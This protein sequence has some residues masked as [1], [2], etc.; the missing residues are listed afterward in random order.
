MTDN[1]D[2]KKIY[3]HHKIIALNEY[4]IINQLESKFN[5]IVFY[6]EGTLLYIFEQ[7]L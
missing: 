5:T 6:C 1:R 2:I 7:N 4:S 3:N